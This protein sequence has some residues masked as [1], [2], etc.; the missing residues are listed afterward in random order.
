MK[1]GSGI[2]GR[3]RWIRADEDPGGVAE[4]LRS[5]AVA[6]VPTESSYGLAVDPLD[7]AAVDRVFRAK[8]RPAV[9]ALPVVA[10][11]PGSLARLG[12]D[13][14]APEL[15][16]AS[17]IWP[18]PLSVLTRI[19][20]PIPASAGLTTLAVRVPAHERLREVL[21]RAGGALTATSA[22]PSGEDPY[23]DPES[24]ARWLESAGVDAVVVDGGRLPGGAPSTLVEW[25]RGGV[26]VVREGRYEIA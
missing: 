26:R 24:A 20:E 23:L 14:G 5:G 2:A 10:A 9:K 15:I 22:N 8:G 17:S 11:E 25:S 16:W 3:I 21:R 18:A 1:R 6:I 12:V 13:P 7:A 4:A 19:R